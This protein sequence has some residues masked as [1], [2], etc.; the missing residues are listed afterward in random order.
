[1]DA[2]YEPGS[3]MNTGNKWE[4]KYILMSRHQ[5]AGQKRIIM[6]ANRCF[7]NVANFEYVDMTVIN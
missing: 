5:N 1:M 7:E 3:Q 6:I 2:T 4:I